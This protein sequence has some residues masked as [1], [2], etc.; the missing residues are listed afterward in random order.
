MRGFNRFPGTYRRPDPLSGVRGYPNYPNYLNV[1]LGRRAA[2]FVTR[3]ALRGTAAGVR[4]GYRHRAKIWPLLAGA[5]M[6]AT[7]WAASWVPD[8]WKTCLML[9]AIAGA[10]LGWNQLRVRTTMKSWAW[11]SVLVSWVTWALCA[12]WTATAA[13]VGPLTI[14]MPG[15]LGGSTLIAQVWWWLHQ[16][17]RDTHHKVEEDIEER[18]TTWVD[19]VAQQWHDRIACEGGALPGS[20]LVGVLPVTR[21]DEETGEEVHIGWEAIIQLPDADHQTWESAVAA[22]R[23]I[24]KVFRVPASQVVVEPPVDGLE[25][26]ARLLVLT[27][28]PLRKIQ[29]HERCQLDPATGYIPIGVHADSSYALWRLYTPGSGANH[30]LIAGT[31]GSGKSGLLNKICAEIRHS[32]LAMLFLGD[33]QGG[34]SCPDWTDGGAHVFAGTVP[35]IRRMLQGVEREM[36]RRQRTRGRERWVDA[37]GRPRRGRGFFNPT[38][39]DPLLMVVIDEAPEVTAD[40]ECK[41]IIA[42]IGKQGRKIGVGIIL[43]VQ[44]PSLSELGNDLS[45]RSMLSSTNIVILRTSDAYSASMGAPM[46]LPVDPVNLP[47]EWPDGS[48]TA[49][50]GF[51]IKAGGR[52]SPMRV[53][54]VEDAYEWASTG[55]PV[56]MPEDT[57]LSGVDPETGQNFFTDWL[58]LLDI[59][60]DEEDQDYKDSIG[61]GGLHV[62][63]VPAGSRDK[64][65]AFLRERG[66][67][68]R[69]SVIADA[70]GMTRSATGMQLRRMERAGLVVQPTGPGSHGKWG[71]APTPTPEMQD[72]LAASG[73]A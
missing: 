1:P 15:V 4:A 65:A 53:Q 10:V 16:Y 55:D 67:P 68:V 35:R 39:E 23:R 30:G 48:T 66:E 62:V 17:V 61:P 63:R 37:K 13:A 47:A 46:T 54:Y 32:G 64:I 69:Q 57:L 14:P 71:L 20:V 52:V 28:N 42:K 18:A 25:D 33:P 24:A 43:L 21:V 59:D 40:P 70:V 11:T 60:D 22:T 12:G 29:K 8:G 9:A 73:V 56:P 44:V 34:E 2:G 27:T 49:G 36:D 51:L 3:H 50:L 38:R 31:T 72:E 41:R 26:S 6:L 7:A 58:E 5:G 45:I 19:Q